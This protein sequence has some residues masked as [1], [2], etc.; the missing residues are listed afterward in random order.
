[1]ESAQL[2]ANRILYSLMKMAAEGV[3]LCKYEMGNFRM[4][5]TFEKVAPGIALSTADAAKLKKEIATYVE[6]IPTLAAGAEVR[7][8]DFKDDS[9]TKRKVVFKLLSIARGNLQVEL[10]TFERLG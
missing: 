9:K 7:W 2:T 10:K 6:G 3:A 5:V 8:P 1:M 4:I